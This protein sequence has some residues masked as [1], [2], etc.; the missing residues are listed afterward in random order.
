VIREYSIYLN[1]KI[2]MKLHD[3]VKYFRE[4]KKI[5]QESIAHELGLNQSQYSRRENGAIK[6]NSE[7]I[8]LLSKILDVNPAEL[9]GDQSIIFNN[10]DQSGGNFAQYINLPEELINQY[11]LRLKEKDEIIQLLKDK[12]NLIESKR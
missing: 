5:S 6:F 4:V 9:F 8:S 11:E 10:K 1:K 3:K 12:I 2:D 7:E